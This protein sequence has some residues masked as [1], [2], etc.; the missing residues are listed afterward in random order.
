MKKLCILLAA[1]AL[2]GSSCKKMFDVKPEDELDVS[3][4][5]RNVYDADAAV[6]GIYGQFMGLAERYV[7]LNELRGDMLEYTDNADEYL[8][9]LST[10]NV[11]PDNPWASPRPF[12]EVILNCNDVLKHFTIMHQEN[13]LQDAEYM[14]RYADVASLRSFLY[15]QLG[16]HY[17]EV[18]Y[19]TSPLETV[20]DLRDEK[21]F[22]RLP[23]NVLLDSLISFTEALAFK[24]EYPAGTTLNITVDGYPTNKWFINK[25]CLLGDLHLWKGNYTQA[26][27]WYREVMETGTTGTVNGSYFSM[28]KVGW[29]SN[30]DID[31]YISYSRAGDAS[32]LVWN[33]QWRIMFEQAMN[34]EGFRRE[35][36]WA[37]PFD[38][39]FGPVNPFVKLFSP[40]GG[41]YLV[42]PS[43]SAIDNWN[44]QEQRPRTSAPLIPGQPYDARGLLTWTELGGQPVVMKYLYNYINYA[45]GMPANILQRDGKW[46]LFRQ[47]HLH[48][49][50][51]EAAN[52][53]GRHRLAWGL[54]NSGF[55]GAFP[56]PTSNVTDYQNTLYEPYPFNF[57]ARNS[58]STGIPYYRS[59]WYRNIGIRARANLVNYEVSA[60]DS[61]L[62]I[63]NGL[64]N[65]TALENGY[66]GTRWP[67]LLRI[68]LRR[69]DPAFLADKIY[70]KLLKDGIPGAADARAKLMSRSNWYLPFD[71]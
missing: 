45:T 9:Q 36:V 1:V 48:M 14:Q 62:Q 65:E 16:I 43:Q 71:L 63:E 44:S 17:G 26:A 53:T 42:K 12:Y 33:T 37:M 61:L 11:T 28:Y 2:T 10:H 21:N 64:I 59:D 22:P 5:Y 60:A 57:D 27:S 19:V 6:I 30:G 32:S 56:A 24:E 67:D 15:L 34:T 49:R 40:V 18:P 47:T 23:F 68:A 66:E 13:K 58:G 54:F 35:W 38:H 50:F 7:L 69:D 55:A 70:D 41:E 25:R 39:K 51:A 31:H 20:D 4:M 8:R 52:R 29:D 46:F 3:D